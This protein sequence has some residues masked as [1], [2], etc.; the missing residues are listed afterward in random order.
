MDISRYL[1]YSDGPGQMN[2]FSE[3]HGMNV[4]RL[5]VAWQFLVRNKAG[6]PLDPKNT[7]LY[8]DL[9]QACIRT[10]AFCIIDIHNYG[11]Y[12]GKIVGQGGPSDEQF[13]SLWWQLG[14]KYRKQDHVIMGLMNEPHT[15]M[16]SG[17]ST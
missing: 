7:G 14:S 6:G 8:D 15:R 12:D 13:A 5:P 11:R 3:K 2:H 9:V 17:I 16:Q 4:F 1:F 10:G